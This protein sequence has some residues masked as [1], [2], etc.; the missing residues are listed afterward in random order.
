MWQG[1]GESMRQLHV[2]EPWADL[3]YTNDKQV[4]ED[5]LARIQILEAKV[6]DLEMRIS[7]KAEEREAVTV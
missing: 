6:R 2:R 4:F 5:L 7:E 3:V 1:R